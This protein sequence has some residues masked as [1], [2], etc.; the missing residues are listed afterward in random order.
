MSRSI[1]FS[2]RHACRHVTCDMCYELTSTARASLYNAKA[3]VPAGIGRRQDHTIARR[4]RRGTVHV[5]AKCS[6]FR[7]GN[8]TQMHSAALP[9]DEQPES[10]YGWAERDQLKRR[11]CSRYR[12]TVRNESVLTWMFSLHACLS[13]ASACTQT[14]S[15]QSTRIKA[16]SLTRTCE[17]DR[18]MLLIA[19]CANKS[20]IK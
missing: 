15:T 10:N 16:P 1:L 2:T 7:H 4:L 13:T 14:P 9:T 11:M 19:Q 3:A 20:V 6:P 5:V 18:P 8:A 17:S 12:A